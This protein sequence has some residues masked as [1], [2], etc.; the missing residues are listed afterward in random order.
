MRIDSSSAM[1]AV[2][3]WNDHM[4]NVSKVV[5]RLST[6]KRINSAEDDPAGIFKQQRLKASIRELDVYIRQT[7][8]DLDS[9]NARSDSLLLDQN[10]LQHMKEIA[11][12]AS[13]D[14]LTDTD[15]QALLRE[16]AAFVDELAAKTKR[17]TGFDI[18]A[19]GSGKYEGELFFKKDD[20]VFVEGDW[21]AE[22]SFM[23]L[24]SKTDGADGERSFDIISE[25]NIGDGAELSGEAIVIEDAVIEDIDEKGIEN[26]AKESTKK[27]EEK[28]MSLSEYASLRIRANLSDLAEAGA[29]AN[30]LSSKLNR[31][32]DSRDSA[33]EQLD[34]H[35]GIDFELEMIEYV[36]EAIRA[37]CA[38]AVS[39]QANAQPER[40]LYLL[41]MPN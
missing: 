31:L 25:A 37:D 24:I 36:K 6:G 41:E 26:I 9:A 5:F 12:Q 8:L 32:F 20:Q 17:E 10:M 1:G 27:T 23:E 2:R 18:V 3:N 13:N 34:R 33:E 14:L 35:E 7:Q 4:Q 30:K 15:R 21:M 19:V 29:V 22:E 28:V 11:A 16:Y 38:A 39:V 40:V